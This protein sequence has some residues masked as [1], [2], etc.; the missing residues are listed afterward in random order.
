MRMLPVVTVFLVAAFVVLLVAA[1]LRPDEFRVQRSARIAAAP[2]RVYAQLADFRAWAA[3]SP[4]EGKD[5]AMKRTYSGAASGVGA[6]YAWEG[7]KEVGTGRMEITEAK[8]PTLVTIRLEFVRPWQATNTAQF[9]LAPDGEGTRVTWTMTGQADLMMKVFGLF[10]D[11]DAKVGRDFEAG[12]ARLG[13]A[14]RTDSPP[15][16]S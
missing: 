9:H 8:E 11:M 4:W 12:L 15:P 1:S 16:R 7:N 5:P 2:E 3:W 14:A 6:V 13:D 10:V